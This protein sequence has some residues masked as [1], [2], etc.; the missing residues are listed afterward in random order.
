[1]ATFKPY[2]FAHFLESKQN[3]CAKII[4][5]YFSIRPV[6]EKYLEKILSPLIEIKNYFYVP[7]ETHR[8]I[9]TFLEQDPNQKFEELTG[10]IKQEYKRYR[11]LFNKKEVHAKSFQLPFIPNI[12]KPKMTVPNLQ[13]AIDYFRSL[14]SSENT[15]E[16]ND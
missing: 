4:H 2:R 5:F 9:L 11:R 8:E 1:M 13:G 3:Y 15:E 6:I 12:F 16:H 10:S 7:E 14:Y